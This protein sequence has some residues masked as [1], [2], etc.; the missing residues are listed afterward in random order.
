MNKTLK[1]IEILKGEAFEIQTPNNTVLRH[2]G[3]RTVWSGFL[4]LEELFTFSVLILSMRCTL[5]V[6]NLDESCAEKTASNNEK[7]H[8][9]LCSLFNPQ[10]PDRCC[11]DSDKRSGC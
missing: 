1:T 7:K 6:F 3:L 9:A 11:F 10:T 4:T 8:C 5:K 2:D